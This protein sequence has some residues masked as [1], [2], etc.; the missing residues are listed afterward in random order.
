MTAVRVIDSI[1]PYV[2]SG[3]VAGAI[4]GLLRDGSVTVEAAGSTSPGGAPLTTDTPM[5]VASNTKPLAAA[6]ALALVED[7][8]L[9]LDHPI[10]RY[11]P[12]LADRRVLRRVDAALDDTVPADRAITVD[13]LLTMRGGF[14]FVTD[15]DSPVVDAAAEA[16]LGMGPPDPSIPLDPQEWVARFAELPLLDQPGTIWRYEFS[17]GILGVV[18]AESA[19]QSLDEL[20]RARLLAPLGM[21][22]TAFVAPSGLPPC[23]ARAES[24]L[25]VFDEAGAESRWA[26]PPTFPDARNG[27]ISTAADLLRF[28]GALLDGGGGVLSSDSVVAM[29]TDHLTDAQRRAPSAQAF[30][31]GHGW[32]Y[33]VQV[34]NLDHDDSV[35]LARYGWGGGFGTLWYTW[36][37]QATAAVMLTQVL[38]PSDEMISSFVGGVEALL[39]TA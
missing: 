14:G 34:V 30:L 24:G 23:F 38:P 2:E 25:E 4:V 27:L 15:G 36:P 20:L 39:G 32:G 13:D 8:V 37:Q 21:D 7:G 16:Q 10:E 31:D 17:Y 6:A 22:D 18:L 26:T 12:A 33:G 35:T 5:R 9:D 3:E 1:R 28:A 19:G 11:L 29:T